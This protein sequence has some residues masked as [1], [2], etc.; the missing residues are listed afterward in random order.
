MNSPLYLKQLEVGPMA[1]FVYLI[2]D[3]HK[4]EVFVIDP[5]WQIDTIFKTAETEGL[6]IT[7]VLITHS[8]YDHCNGIEELLKKTNVPIYV[9]KNEVDFSNSMG[10]AGQ[11]FWKFPA[12]Q[13][14][15]VD[16]GEKIA[17]GDV[18]VTFVHTPG[19]TPGSQCF[20]IE[21]NLVSGDTL[22]IRGCGRSDLP[23]GNAEDLYNS[24]TQKLKKLP[25]DTV[26]LPGHNYTDESMS[27]IK[28]EKKRNPYFL[29]NSLDMFLNMVGK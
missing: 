16:S 12:E 22:F 28:D 18:R 17:I 25:D 19:H 29:C 2:G 23:G 3:S 24:L 14:K 10:S 5:A 1:N 7:G 11:L 6:K 20:L 9:N 8:H 26:L 21:N 13:T 4:K 15:K 27:T